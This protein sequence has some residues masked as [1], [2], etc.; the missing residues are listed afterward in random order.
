MHVKGILIVCDIK[1]FR[2]Q[3]AK[4]YGLQVGVY[5][6][7]Y[8]KLGF[9]YAILQLLDG[10]V[11]AT[12]GPHSV[13]ADRLGTLSCPSRSARPRYCQTYRNGFVSPP[14][15]FENLVPL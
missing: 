13:L 10:L 9:A 12:P 14:Y 15:K 1:R 8:D 2:H 3:V 11:S 5:T 7:W 4:I 6:N